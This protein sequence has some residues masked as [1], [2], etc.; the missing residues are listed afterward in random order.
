MLKFIDY[1]PNQS[2]DFESHVKRVIPPKRYYPMVIYQQLDL[3]NADSVSNYHLTLHVIDMIFAFQMSHKM[4]VTKLKQFYIKG[5]TKEVGKDDKVE[6][7]PKL[8]DALISS[9]ITFILNFQVGEFSSE[10]I[11]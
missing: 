8:Q 6:L 10:S 7:N 2:V 4:T 9:I 3:Q 1:C 5:E 11:S